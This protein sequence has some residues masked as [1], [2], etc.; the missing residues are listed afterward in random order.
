MTL[1]KDDIVLGFADFETTHAGDIKERTGLTPTVKG[2]MVYLYNGDVNTGIIP[3]VSVK[4]GGL[5]V[6]RPDEPRKEIMTHSVPEILLS[7]LENKIDRCYYHNL[8]FDESFISAYIMAK[9]GIIKLTNE[10][11]VCVSSRLMGSKGVL[12]TST[13]TFT[14]NRDPISHRRV[15]HTT[16]LM[17]SAKIWTIEL[18]KLGESFGIEKGHEALTVGCNAEMEEYCL[19]DCRILTEAMLWYF[20]KVQ[21]IAHIKYGY[22]TSASTAYNLGIYSL[23][24]KLGVQTVRDMFP[25]CTLEN[26]FPIW[27]REGYKGATPLLD[28]KQRGKKLKNVFVFDFNSHY[29]TIVVKMKLP[30]G[31]PIPLDAYKF[32]KEIDTINLLWV[33][34]MKIYATVKEGHR[35]TFMNKC[36]K[37][38]ETLATTINNYDAEDYEILTSVDWEILKRDYDIHSMTVIESFG[39]NYKIGVFK[40]F[41]EYWYN[42]KCT[43]PDGS[44]LKAFAKLIINSF[45]G[46]FGT[47]PE[48]EQCYYE[49]NEDG[50]LRV[51]TDPETKMDKHPFYLPFAMFITSYGRDIISQV[52]NAIGW[53][54]VVYTDTD[55]VHV[56]GLPQDE[57][58]KRI[59]EIGYKIDSKEL[60]ALK[61]EST[62]P[63][64]IYVRAKGYIHFD[65]EGN[66]IEIKMAGVNSFENLKTVDD[67]Y[68]K[69]IHGVQKR[70]YNV[71]GGKLI[72]ELPTEIDSELMS[73]KYRIKGKSSEVSE[74]IYRT[75][76]TDIMEKYGYGY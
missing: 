29:P 20:K 47:N 60:G 37:N 25:E 23:Q 18:R 3:E 43:S 74:E 55:S 73:R 38:G 57:T 14:G 19:Q 48:K 39:F 26:G 10:W 5:I 31:L 44:A 1:N 36:I 11:D 63:Y 21:E 17:D 45:Y 16:I 65:E 67:I 71:K 33:A 50:C 9:G 52:C 61:H 24:A 22:M 62:S 56:Y 69:K 2:N 66:A 54:H 34:K 42:I 68:D 64:G 41:I 35:P 28:L 32:S 27:L 13:L 58:I 40:E 12:Y 30:Y 15:H 8:K 49:M 46:K 7:I 72:M 75:K 59:T 53:E 70:A 6:V 51:K 4:C 76:V